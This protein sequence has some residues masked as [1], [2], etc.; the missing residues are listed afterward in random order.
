M[1]AGLQVEQVLVIAT[2]LSENALTFP[3]LGLASVPLMG[4]NGHRSRQRPGAAPSR[5][6]LTSSRSV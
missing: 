1:W 2:T 6:T 5:E 3:V 4:R